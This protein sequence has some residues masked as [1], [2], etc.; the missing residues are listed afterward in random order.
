M[1]DTIKPQFKT[2]KNVLLRLFLWCMGENCGE[3]FV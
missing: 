3:S 2:K 1:K